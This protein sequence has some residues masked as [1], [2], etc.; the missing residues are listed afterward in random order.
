MRNRARIGIRAAGVF[1][2]VAATGIVPAQAAGQ[3]QG[4]V[5]LPVRGM[6]VDGTGEDLR[7]RSSNGRYRLRDGTWVDVWNDIRITDREAAERSRTHL[8][9]TGAGVDT[10]DLFHFDLGHGE[11]LVTVFVD[12][13]CPHCHRAMDAMSQL[14][15]TYTFRLVPVALLGKASQ[16]QVEALACSPAK[17]EDKLNA[18]VTKAV[19]ELE[20]GGCNQ[21]EGK[22]VGRTRITARALG[23]TGVPFI[24][25]PDNRVIQGAPR[26]L[27]TALNGKGEG[28][29]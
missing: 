28:D 9:L 12:P 3:Q 10:Q 18:L 6:V 5:R 2:A 7:V 1:L 19:P 17:R 29:G 14:T 24:I 23:V 15:D 27:R 4:A 26:D 13:R 8:S 25:T 16:K 22:L 20:E 11:Q 21:A